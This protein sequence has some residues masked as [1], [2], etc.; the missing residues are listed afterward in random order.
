MMENKITIQSL[1]NK[2]DTTVT[3][4]GWVQTVRAQKKNQFVVLR[5]HT[6]MVQLFYE[7]KDDA[8]EIANLLAKLT[9]ESI[10]EVTGK[11]IANP[12]VKLRGIE[13]IPEKVKVLSLAQAPLP[14]G[15][16]TVDESVLLDWRFLDLRAPKNRLIF[17]VQTAIE[18]AMRDFWNQHEFIEI[19]SPKLM[20]TA[21]ES[22]AEVFCVEYFDTK[23]YLAQSPQFYKQMAIAAGFDKVFEIAP[24]FRADPSFTP[25]H[26]TEFTSVDIEIGWIKSHHDVMDVQQAWLQHVIKYVKEKHGAAIKEILNTEINVPTLPFPRI[27]LDEARKILA[28]MGHTIAQEDDLDPQGERLMSQYVKET[29]GHEFVF[30]IDYPINV[31][32]FYHMRHEDNPNLTKSFDLLWKGLETTSGAQ[33]EHRAEQLTRQAV[34]KGFALEPLQYYLDFFKYGCPPHGGL[35]LGLARVVMCLL[36]LKNIREATFLFRGPKRLSP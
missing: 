35:G 21:S 26:S 3:V 10:I 7:R 30:I 11:V 22:G 25:R 17:E 29:F 5:D 19:H 16:D 4:A 23:A 15:K 8:D 13:L 34:E 14:I 32:P 9:Q 36:D 28:K 6:G 27:P 24:A 33:R 12:H 31:R 18:Y 1:A 20:G 2:I